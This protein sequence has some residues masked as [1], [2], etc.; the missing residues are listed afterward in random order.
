MS[1]RTRFVGKRLVTT[2]RHGSHG[3]SAPRSPSKVS[4]CYGLLRVI[5]VSFFT[6]VT[7]FADVT[8]LD[9][10]AAGVP[11]GALATVTDVPG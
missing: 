9:V 6:V 10:V 11:T 1:R 8:V 5:V 3:E 7:D 2:T 4:S